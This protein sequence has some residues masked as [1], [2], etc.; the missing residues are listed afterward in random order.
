MDSWL[1]IN[2]SNL[3]KDV[4]VDLCLTLSRFAMFPMMIKAQVLSR[5]LPK[6]HVGNEILLFIHLFNRGTLHSFG[7][8]SF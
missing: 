8:I 2:L 6:L 4:L 5:I 7:T 1:K 3:R